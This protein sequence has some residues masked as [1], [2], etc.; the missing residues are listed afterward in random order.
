MASDLPR[1]YM[2]PRLR[3]LPL[4]SGGSASRTRCVVRIWSAPGQVGQA[5]GAV[6]GVAVAVAVDLD[7]L[8]GLD[9]H[10]HLHRVAG[11]ARMDRLFLQP[12]LDGDAGLERLG[13]PREHDEQA[14]AQQLDHPAVVLLE[15]LGQRRRQLRDEAAG[16]LVPEPLE[17]AGAPNQVS[18][19][20]GGHDAVSIRVVL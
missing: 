3:S 6:D 7:H 16:G 18:K 11:A 13:L 19:D 8:A 9:A 4:Q 10:L 15:D 20:D 2:G 17:D 14:V 5:G 12:L 1:R